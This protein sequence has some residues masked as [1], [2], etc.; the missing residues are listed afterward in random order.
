MNRILAIIGVAA[1]FASL[2]SYADDF[3]A[4]LAGIQSEWA[5][6]NYQTKDKAR[7]AAFATEHPFSLP[8]PKCN[9]SLRVL[10]SFIRRTTR[11]GPLKYFRSTVRWSVTSIKLYG[12]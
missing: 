2:P 9:L 5:T 1:A 4:D 12:F 8:S 10:P 7:D 3:G 6:A 11:T